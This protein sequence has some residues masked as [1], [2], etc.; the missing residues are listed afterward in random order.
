MAI[1]LRIVENRLIAIC[2]ARSIPKEGDMYLDDGQ[3]YA[4][5]L[6]FARDFEESLGYDLPKDPIDKQLVEQEESNN[7]NRLWWEETYN[8]KKGD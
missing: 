7:P 2:A 1:R 4:L 3:H 8:R 5:M 6:K